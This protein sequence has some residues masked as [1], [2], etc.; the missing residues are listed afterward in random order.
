MDINKIEF[1]TVN[2]RNEIDNRKKT[3]KKNKV[4][5]IKGKALKFTKKRA[6]KVN[7]SW[8]G[9]STRTSQAKMA[10]K[11]PSQEQVET[12]LAQELHPL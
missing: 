2:K 6:I 3:S 7:R 1:E 8:Q 5:K 11:S 10:D 12:W 4:S 9:H